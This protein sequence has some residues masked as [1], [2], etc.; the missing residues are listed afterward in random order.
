M[1]EDDETPIP[2]EGAE[3]EDLASLPVE[4]EET[5]ASEQPSRKIQAIGS[6]GVTRQARKKQ[7]ERVPNLTGTGAI[8]CRVFHSKIT[9]AAME[10]MTETINDWLD[11]EGIEVKHVNQV[12]GIME[13]KTPEP[14]VIV[15]VWY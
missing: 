15:T 1:S 6:A 2:L 13:G 5:P 10:H 3:E 7:F 12:V 11:G 4:G 9:I 14:N 8:R